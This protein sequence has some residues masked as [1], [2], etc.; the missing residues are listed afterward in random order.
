MNPETNFVHLTFD[1]FSK[2]KRTREEN[3]EEEDE[4]EVKEEPKH[5]VVFKVE[6]S[7]IDLEVQKS[8]TPKHVT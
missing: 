7:Q 2:E 8:H 3:V 4:E 6:G 1:I 5:S